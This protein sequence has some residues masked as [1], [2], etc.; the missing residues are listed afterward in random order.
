MHRHCFVY[1]LDVY[2]YGANNYLLSFFSIF[3]QDGR[4]HQS[5]SATEVLFLTVAYD[6]FLFG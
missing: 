5:L 1:E 6:W 4:I 3:I 2:E